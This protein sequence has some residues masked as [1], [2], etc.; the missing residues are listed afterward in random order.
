M[1]IIDIIILAILALSVVSGMYKGFITSTLALVGF[2]GSWIAAL[3]SYQYL[4]RAVN[5]NESLMTFF[6]SV[7]GAV[8][9]FKTASLSSTP[10]AT[11]STEIIEQAAQEVNLP[12]ISEIFKNN[13]IGKVF[14]N[15]LSTIG[16]Y[17][18]QTLLNTALDVICFILMFAVIYIA[19]LLI[20]NLLNNVFRFP[21]LR[22]FDWAIGGVFG[23]VR[24]LVIVMLIF[25][26]TPTIATALDNMNITGLKDLIEQSR[27]GSIFQNSNFVQHTL[28]QILS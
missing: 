21:V 1:N 20:V 19:V 3:A 24:G 15:E 5:A 18:T 25:A 9:L 8:D 10:V 27:I 14:G 7:V 16:E 6:R 26:V 28:Q 22:H 17:L 12:L 4:V 11:A 13:M 2:V 23:L